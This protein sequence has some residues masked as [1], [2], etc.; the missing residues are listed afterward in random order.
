MVLSESTISIKNLK[1]SAGFVLF[2][3][4]VGL[5]IF[6]GFNLPSFFSVFFRGGFPH[7]LHV[8]KAEWL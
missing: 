4:R 8:I 3:C 2:E 7:V 6:Q 5:R 1:R